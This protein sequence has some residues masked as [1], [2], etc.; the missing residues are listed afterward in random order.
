MGRRGGSAVG[1]RGA[2]RTPAL[3]HS[4]NEPH[5]TLEDN[6]AAW[7]VPVRFALGLVATW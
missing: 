6:E 2:G 5:A 7:V 4:D 3:P 1:R